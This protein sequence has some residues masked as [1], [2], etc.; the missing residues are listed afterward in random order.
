MYLSSIEVQGFKTFAQKT[1][2]QVPKPSPDH[3]PTTV[4]VGP[5]GSGKSNLSDAIRWCLGEQSL[6]QLR[7]K[8]HEDVIFSGSSGKGRSGFAEVTMHFETEPGDKS[9]FSSIAIARHLGRDGESTY[10]LNGRACRLQDI[11]LFLAEHG[12][13]Q[14]S[15]SVIGQGM[16]DHILTASPEE[17][18]VFFDDAT[19]VRSLQLKRHQ[20]WLKL[21]RSHTHLQEVMRLL[22]EMEPRVK[23][24][25][26]QMDRLAEREEVEKE[27]QDVQLSYF[28]H[29]WWVI[30]NSLIALRA[31]LKKEADH[32]LEQ[33]AT[34]AQSEASLATLQKELLE[35]TK[36]AQT[37]IR[38]EQEVYRKLQQ[39]LSKAERN[40]LEA[41]R[42]V[43]LAR[44]RFQTSWAPLPLEEIINELETLQVVESEIMRLLTS[45]EDIS[46]IKNQVDVLFQRIKQLHKQLIKPK[47][48]DFVVNPVLHARIKDAQTLVDKAKE[49]IGTYDNTQSSHTPGTQDSTQEHHAFLDVQKKNRELQRVIHEIEMRMHRT[50]LEITKAQ[51]HRESIER[52]I[53]ETAPALRKFITDNPPKNTVKNADELRSRMLKLMHKRDMIGGIEGNVEEEY[54]EVSEK[55]DF[56]KTQ[57]GD[58]EGAIGSSRK[59]IRELDER[60]ETQSEKVFKDI[61]KAFQHYFKIL[62][63]G[64]SCDL[65]QLTDTPHE[66]E[67][68]TALGRALEA[69]AEEKT[70]DELE[71][72]A[73]GHIVGVDITATP[74]GKKMKSLN[75]LSGGEKAMTSIALLCAIMSVNP[76][77]FVVLDEVDAALDEANTLRFANILHELRK[78]SQFIVITHNRATME[79][80][81]VLYGVTMGEDG[82]SS[83]LSVKLTDVSASTTRR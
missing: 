69:L 5:N 78:H 71:I 60:I 22:E 54:Q 68:D 19:G 9:D 66:E 15:Y 42:E 72:T 75:L 11:Q 25:K 65:I 7:G 70:H 45:G 38:E 21:K 77:P 51:T 10:L 24:L 56:L 74:P 83:L 50:D 43:E 28:S 82:V 30:E 53:Q 39:D 59:L 76:S 29:E 37:R 32:K 44:V 73:S 2:I 64:G 58:L 49:A 36:N 81:D 35:K 31:T 26:R 57:S 23:L 61:R 63:G 67:N 27:L 80:A 41:E 33:E 20:T 4:I 14:R 62:F 6:K 8:K 79:Q 1:V 47:N 17:R 52:E 40:L 18:K 12:I 13:G 48:E 34:L 46:Q 3:R 55:F 16:I